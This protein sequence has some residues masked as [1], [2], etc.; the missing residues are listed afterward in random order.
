MS[1]P[2]E[3]IIMLGEID[4]PRRVL[5]GHR[6]QVNVS[7]I[8][9]CKDRSMVNIGLF[10]H[11]SG[12]ILE[13]RIS[14]L[15]GN[16]T[17]QYLFDL[18][19]PDVEVSLDLEVLLRYWHLG[20]WVYGKESLRK[21]ISIRIVDQVQLRI[22]L[23]RAG[24]E[25]EIGNVRFRAD[26]SGVVQTIMK[27]GRYLV[28]VPQNIDLAGGSRLTFSVW[29]DGSRS[30]PR[31]VEVQGDLT[32][33]VTYEVEYLLSV[34]SGF[35][36]SYGGGWY[37]AGREVTLSVPNMITIIEGSN[38][39]SRRYVFK[40]WSGDV[41]ASTPTIHVKVSSP[42]TVEAVWVKDETSNIVIMSSIVIIILNIAFMVYLVFGRWMGRSG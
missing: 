21:P 38:L 7:V 9:S 20:F 19:A 34:N 31:I 32:L 35:G 3:P 22:V 29:S 23:P 40:C 1:E 27:V 15:T 2:S 37:P 17:K 25:V 28:K 39:P 11:N 6:F 13:P 8:Y 26:D 10:S 18:Q 16:G 12:S 5:P 41:E 33:N 42:M 4:Y 30:N 14:Y 24:V 36:V